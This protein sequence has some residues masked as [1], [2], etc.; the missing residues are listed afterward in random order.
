MLRD[1]ESCYSSGDA[2][3]NSVHFD[4]NDQ[5]YRCFCHQ[6]HS[7]TGVKIIA[8]LLCLTV[9]L[10]LWS[11]IWHIM[12]SNPTGNN[13]VLTSFCQLFIGAAISSSVVYALKTENASFLSPYLLLQGK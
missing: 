4:P 12:S 9:L 13:S 7:T 8:A 5:K 1:A 2:D 3:L 6:C 11:L 10:E